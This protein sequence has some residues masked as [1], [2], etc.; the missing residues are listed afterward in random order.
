LGIGVL[1]LNSKFKKRSEEIS[2]KYAKACQLQ[3]AKIESAVGARVEVNKIV[4]DFISQEGWDKLDI[5]VGE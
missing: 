3:V 1:V 2:R 4:K 5:K